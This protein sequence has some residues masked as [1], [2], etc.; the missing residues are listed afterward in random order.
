MKK[1]FSIIL[2]AFVLLT[3]S[4]C[5]AQTPEPKVIWNSYK[6]LPGD[7]INISGADFSTLQD[8]KLQVITD[9]TEAD[10][11]KARYSLKVLTATDDLIQGTIPK[12]VPKGLYAIWIVSD[13]GVSKPVYVNKPDITNVPYADVAHGQEIRMAG[14][15]FLNPSTNTAV[16]MKVRLKN[17]E[18]G[19]FVEAKITYVSEYEVRF[20]IPSNAEVGAVYQVGYNNGCGGDGEFGYAR[21]DEH[22]IT[23]HASNEHT[24][25]IKEKFGIDVW[26]AGL[27]DTKKVYN[28]RDYGIVSDS[29]NS[30]DEKIDRFFKMVNSAGGGL[31][32]FPEGTYLVG[33]VDLP[34]KVVLYGDGA[35]KTIF[36]YDDS[37]EYPDNSSVGTITM[38]HAGMPYVAITDVCIE[39]N[40]KRPYE[41]RNVRRIHGKV[42]CM[43]LGKAYRSEVMG[44]PVPEGHKFEG[45]H[46]KDV[47]VRNIDGSGITLKGDYPAVIENCDIRVAK[48]TTELGSKSMILDSYL[49]G[50]ER[51][52]VDSSSAFGWLSGCTLEGEFIDM[53]RETI[54]TEYT[55]KD[56]STKW[57]TTASS[58]GSTENRVMETGARGHYIANNKVLGEFGTYYSNELSANDG[59]GFLAQWTSSNKGAGSS[60]AFK[61]LSADETSI[62]PGD[63]AYPGSKAKN[64]W[65]IVIVDGR[66]TGQLRRITSIDE[67]GKIT[68]DRPW[69]VVPDETSKF[70]SDKYIYNKHIWVHNEVSAN[71]RKAA[72]MFYTSSF[73]VTIADN[74]TSDSGGIMFGTGKRNKT[75]GFISYHATVSGNLVTRDGLGDR[76]SSGSYDYALGIGLGTDS[77]TLGRDDGVSLEF[78]DWLSSVNWE[79]R[80]NRIERDELVTYNAVESRSDDLYWSGNGISVGAFNNRGTVEA[81][82]SVIEN[83]E[84]VNTC[85]GVRTS[86]NSTYNM[87][88]RNNF[89]NNIWKY[90]GNGQYSKGGTG[91]GGENN[92]IIE[93]GFDK[94][95][96]AQNAG[97]DK[98]Y[99]VFD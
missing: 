66:G 53:D 38:M 21:F 76:N 82:G 70:I 37:E 29:V 41:D 58:Y 10:I 31:V 4:V 59:E 91:L 24:A 16:G 69:D 36:S 83:N 3:T 27:I 67:N 78:S 85:N 11:K 60:V 73:D 43:L 71:I 33:H 2:F 88:S 97:I 7:T 18:T 96:V 19:S 45:Y 94:N 56:G 64:S 49:Y 99:Y 87:I 86:Q 50:R 47:N 79:F 74:I 32:Y 13:K 46:V 75:A 93:D 92:I 89:K 90:S 84:V 5:F 55:L 35:D 57:N 12:N 20:I 25:Y 14:R 26:W 98:N 48:I 40:V 81:K 15:N 39:N 28:A 1:F 63:G 9:D 54:Y 17:A 68:V 51:C 44:E 23:V 77:G 72:F 61:V 52:L 42:W 34:S 95:V 30:Q 6:A 65:F 80:N 8:I 22:P 62:T